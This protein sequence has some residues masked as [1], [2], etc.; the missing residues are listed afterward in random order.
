MSD[1]HQRLKQ[2]FEHLNQEAVRLR[3]RDFKGERYRLNLR[4]GLE[5]QQQLRLI[6]LL[7]AECKNDFCT[8]V[9]RTAAK[10]HLDQL[11]STHDPHAWTTLE[12]CA[13]RLEGEGDA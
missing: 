7:T 10:D 4:I 5:L 9:I 8:R 3:R 11:R 13:K 1:A 2:K 6:K 12:E